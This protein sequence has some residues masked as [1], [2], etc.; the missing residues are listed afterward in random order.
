[1]PSSCFGPFEIFHFTDGAKADTLK[2]G[3]GISM[4]ER[5]L[6]QVFHGA[7]QDGNIMSEMAR[8]E[9]EKDG[10]LIHF[11][12]WNIITKIGLTYILS[13]FTELS[14]LP[15]AVALPGQAD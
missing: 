15:E 12:G 2:I 6:L 13:E 11:W 9:L 10:R 1:M 4:Y 7:T 8:D 14:S 3:I 5:Q